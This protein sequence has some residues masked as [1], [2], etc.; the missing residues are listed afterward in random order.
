MDGY[1]ILTVLSLRDYNTRLVVLCILL[2]GCACGMIGSFL[3]LR[4][5]SLMG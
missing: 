1:D 2:L 3:L 5:R 4:K